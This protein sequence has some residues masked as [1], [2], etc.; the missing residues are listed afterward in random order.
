VQSGM[1]VASCDY[2]IH[3]CHGKHIALTS[4]S[5]W[6]ETS[7]SDAALR[8]LI[9]SLFVFLLGIYILWTRAQSSVMCDVDPTL[10]DFRTCHVDR[11][12]NAIEPLFA[13]KGIPLL[14]PMDS[15]STWFTSVRSLA[16]TDNPGRAQTG[17]RLATSPGVSDT[18]IL[19]SG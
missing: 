12:S 2:C 5:S 16:E 3:S 18:S 7:C 13:T 17:M 4:Q 10:A 9:F 6:T 8:P 1:R 15:E 11:C 19:C 14:P